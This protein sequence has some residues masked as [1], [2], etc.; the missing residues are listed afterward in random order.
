[1]FVFVLTY[2]TFAF[3]G[4]SKYNEELSNI[5]LLLF[6]GRANMIN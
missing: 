2:G 6:G 1:M 4:H 5:R 3:G